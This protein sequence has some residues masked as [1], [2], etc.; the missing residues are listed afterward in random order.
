MVAAIREG[1]MEQLQ[2]ERSGPPRLVA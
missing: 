1:V 2:R